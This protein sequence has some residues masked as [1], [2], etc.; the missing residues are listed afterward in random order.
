MD[1]NKNE[2]KKLQ[3]MYEKVCNDYKDLHGDYKELANDYSTLQENYKKLVEVTTKQS[4]ELNEL[5]KGISKDSKQGSK[6]L[7]ALFNIK[8]KEEIAK[9]LKNGVEGILKKDIDINRN[10]QQSKIP[11]WSNILKKD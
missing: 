3:E 11:D 6:N 9:L 10:I 4:E 2:I 7:K 8:P 5:I 1:K